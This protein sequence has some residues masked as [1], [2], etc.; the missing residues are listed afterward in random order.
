MILVKIEDLKAGMILAQ[1]VQSQQGLL[2]LDAGAKITKKNI[3]IFK[4]WGVNEIAIKGDLAQAKGEGKPPA[5]VVKASVEMD[6]KKKFSDVLDNSV[7]VEIFK[8]ASSQ[9][10][11]KFQNKNHD[12]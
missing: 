1:P 5:D 9:L 12:N 11:K 3:R 6:L 4:S 2:L 8:A 10:R 7:M